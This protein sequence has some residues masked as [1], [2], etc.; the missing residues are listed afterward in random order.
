MNK[1][2]QK[3]RPL[4]Q[5]VFTAIMGGLAFVIMFFDFPLPFIPADFLKF[6]FSE[7]PALITAIFFGSAAGVMVEFLKN[8]L[9]FIMK[10]GGAVPLVG[11][12]ANFLAGTLFILG[13][14]WIFNKF[15][16]NT[17]LFLGLLLG[18]LLMTVMMSLANYFVLLPLYGISGVQKLPLITSAI[19]PFNLF[20]G[21]LITIAMM[22]IYVSLKSV[23]P[24]LRLQ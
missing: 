20:K 10:G 19:V 2:N 6:D 1:S 5:L 14:T 21:A 3:K 8:V 7:I 9:H 23:E 24:R 15:R 18:S 13:M 11:E 4:N 12:L 17:G 16:T 22:P